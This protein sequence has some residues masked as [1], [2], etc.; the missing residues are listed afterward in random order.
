MR[1]RALI[2]ALAIVIFSSPSSAGEDRT[3]S[4]YFLVLSGDPATDR[5]PLMS[6]RADVH[7]A[8]VI[9][10]VQVTQVY[11]NE[12]RS[13]LE[14]IYVFPASTRAAVYAMKMQI[15]QRIIE[16]RIEERE[17]ARVDYESARQEGRTASLLEQQRPNVFSMNVANI[18][19]G[20]EIRVDFEYTE[21]LVPVDK[22]YEFVYPTVVGPRYSETPESSAPDRERFVETPYQREGEEPL[23]AFGL[24]LVLRSGVPIAGIESASHPVA[25]QMQ[26]VRTARIHLPESREHGNRDFVLR[27]SLAGGR[28]ETGMLLY[29]GPDEKFFLL[30]MEPPERVEAKDVVARE[31]VFVVDVSGSMNGFPLDTAKSLMK[32][33]LGDLGADDLFNLVLFAGT[34]S[35]FRKRSV[36]ASPG[37]IEEAIDFLGEQEGSGGT[38]LLPALRRALDLP[39][40]GGSSRIVVV[41]TDGYVDVEKEAFE[42]VR[43]HLDEM[44]LFSFGIGSSVNRFLIE[45]MARAGMGEP[46]VVLRSEEANEAA[47]RFRAYIERPLMQGIRLGF[48]GGFDAYDIEPAAIPDLFAA[49]PIIVAGKYRGEPRG[50]AV[51]RGHVPG[52]ELEGRLAL[53]QADRSEDNRALRTLWARQKIMQLS[54]MNR[55]QYDAALVQRVTELGLKYG[56]LTDYTS[57]VAT[58][59]VVRADGTRAETVKQPLPLPRGVGGLA[60]GESMT[61]CEAAPFYS[62]SSVWSLFHFGVNLDLFTL[63]GSAGDGA[64]NHFAE[65][66][67]LLMAPMLSRF[68][69]YFGAGMGVFAPRVRLGADLLLFDRGESGPML[70]LGGRYIFVT[71]VADAPD[72]YEHFDAEFDF[73]FGFMGEL[74]LGWR[75]VLDPFALQLVGMYLVGPMWP[76]KGGDDRAPGELSPEGMAVFHGGT[77]SLTFEW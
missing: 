36:S 50:V 37:H 23:Y 21:L 69:L 67:F 16:A 38:S 60:V 33:L 34:G 70:K 68:N 5:L 17:K 43:A 77:V 65:I 75:F 56:L 26:G 47:D 18:L 63:T 44:N 3:L 10:Q 25:V 29:P 13:T 62:S 55:N 28:I 72:A 11:K 1:K 54:D 22:V 30:M 15:G 14:A 51:V 6:T 48:E 52:E 49:R 53:A 4:P 35:L 19:P 58:D 2:A 8:G 40:T 57:F 71:W 74:G 9:A 66:D 39:R 46:F 73:A 59:S 32:D 64:I 76:V 7:I 27:Y 20:D 42:L 12:G 24:D 41:V 31:Y 45:G 61:A